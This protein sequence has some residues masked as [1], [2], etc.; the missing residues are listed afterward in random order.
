[1]KWIVYM[2]PTDLPQT[3]VLNGQVQ[4][5]QPSQVV[6]KVKITMK[7]FFTRPLQG[8]SPGHR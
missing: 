8:T 3:I 1:V 4:Y 7:V 2:T 6:A 5:V